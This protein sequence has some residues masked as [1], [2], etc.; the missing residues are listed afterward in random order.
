M[1]QPSDVWCVPEI[2]GCLQNP[3]KSL[4]EDECNE[5]RCSVGTNDF[6]LQVFTLDQL[7]VSDSHLHFSGF[8]GGIS[9]HTVS[10]EFLEH[11]FVEITVDPFLMPSAYVADGSLSPSFFHEALPVFAGCLADN[12][13]V[14][15]PASVP[16]F[17]LICD[18][19][20]MLSKTYILRF[21]RKSQ[22]QEIRLCKATSLLCLPDFGKQS[23]SCVLD[24]FSLPLESAQEIATGK[25]QKLLLEFHPG[26]EAAVV[27]LALAK[28]AT[29]T[30]NRYGPFVASG[31]DRRQCTRS[32][33]ET[34]RL[35]AD[36]LSFLKQQ[37]T[38]QVFQ[39]K[40]SQRLKPKS[41]YHDKY[42]NQ[43]YGIPDE[44]AAK[45]KVELMQPRF[46]P[47]STGVPAKCRTPSDSS[48][49]FHYCANCWITPI[50]QASLRAPNLST[51]KYC[52]PSSGDD[53]DGSASGD[54][55][56]DDFDYDARDHQ[57]IAR[58]RHISE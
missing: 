24:T 3:S 1:G 9:G 47:L 51:S 13:C 10:P 46:H 43:Q 31:F 16:T 14:Y 7:R 18:N 34:S 15:I 39:P 55:L 11:R 25:L 27:Y 40:V 23:M 52:L 37:E 6:G 28:K 2:L 33:G 19:W 42:L 32:A 57:I 44:R 49:P 22:T 58:H 54:D 56:D 29:P 35:V 45:R 38:S 41:P 50:R 4:H 48:V 20:E 8:L 53:E 5:A 26:D 30:I 12:C 17:S 36:T 21:L